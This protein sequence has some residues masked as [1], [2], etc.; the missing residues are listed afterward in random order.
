MNL[1]GKKSMKLVGKKYRFDI[2]KAL[3]KTKYMN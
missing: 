3:F 2:Q 1:V